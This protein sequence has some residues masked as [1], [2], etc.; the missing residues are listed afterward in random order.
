MTIIRLHGHLGSL[1]ARLCGTAGP[2][3]FV[4][5]GGMTAGEEG[6]KSTAGEKPNIFLCN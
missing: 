2:I 5:G 1:C 6:T 4:M 3:M